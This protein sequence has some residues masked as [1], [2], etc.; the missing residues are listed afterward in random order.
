[1]HGL[2]GICM[3]CARVAWHVHG[4]HGICMACARVAWHVHGWCGMCTGGVACARVAWHVHGLRGMCTGCVA[5]A[6]VAWHVHGW[7]GM[8]TG[9]VACARVA[10]HV[11]GSLCP[12]VRGCPL[13]R[14]STI[15]G[16]T[17]VTN[18]G[19]VCPYDHGMGGFLV[20]CAESAVLFVHVDVS[21]ILASAVS[22]SPPH[23]QPQPPVQA[24][25]KGWEKGRVSSLR[26]KEEGLWTRLQQPMTLHMIQC[27]FPMSC[28]IAMIMCGQIWLGTMCAECLVS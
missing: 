6:R 19:W 18:G 21:G 25:K 24:L 13:F 10:W 20:I 15:G 1:M 11:H 5:C 4:L 12:L 27:L 28:D 23:H 16:S 7:R 14:V 3:A 9:C 8:C 26:R 17:V 2:R 22:T